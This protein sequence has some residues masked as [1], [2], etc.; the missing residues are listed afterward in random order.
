LNKSG[1][2]VEEELEFVIVEDEEELEDEEEHE[3]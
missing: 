1:S 3:E 2:T